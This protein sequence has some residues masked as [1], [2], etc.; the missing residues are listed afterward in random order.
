MHSSRRSLLRGGLSSAALAVAASAGL[1]RP[2]SAWSAP[3][4]WNAARPEPSTAVAGI[5][6]ELRDANPAISA[7]IL[8]KAPDIAEDGASVFV[9]VYSILPDLDA[10]AV[11]VDRNPQP[12]AAVFHLSRQTAPELKFRVKVAQTGNIWVVARSGGRFYRN[13]KTVKVTIGGCGAGFN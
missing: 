4:F 9:E 1:L 11:F 6:R 10:F 13:F 8:I 2:V 3:L 5:L 7:Q 12:M